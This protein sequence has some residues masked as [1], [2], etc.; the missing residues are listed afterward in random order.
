MILLAFLKEEKLKGE[1]HKETLFD[2]RS[3]AEVTWDDFV[4]PRLRKW[5]QGQQACILRD[6][7]KIIGITSV[8]FHDLRATFITNMLAQGTPLVKVMSVVGHKKMTTTDGYLRLSGV[9]LD[10]ITDKLSYS[11]PKSD[12]YSKVI[13]LAK[14]RG[15]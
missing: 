7:C 10:G 8:R 15:M 12:I 11:A 2:T 3:K 1:K 13:S 9:G 4:L 6:F 5:K 14:M